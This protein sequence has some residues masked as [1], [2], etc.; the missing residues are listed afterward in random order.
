V[1]PKDAGSMNINTVCQRRKEG[2]EM[3][4]PSGIQ[5]M[6]YLSSPLTWPHQSAFLTGLPMTCTHP[7]D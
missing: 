7:R 4:D 6:V 2:T 1:L 5:E 3:R